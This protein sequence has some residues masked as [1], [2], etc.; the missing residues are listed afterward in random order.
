MDCSADHSER[1]QMLEN[2]LR[3]SL[4]RIN[5][6]AWAEK[7]YEALGEPFPPMRKLKGKIPRYQ[8]VL[9]D[10]GKLEG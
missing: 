4:D 10:A 5:D 2:L 1:I 3:Q 6:R 8:Q 7:V 9:I